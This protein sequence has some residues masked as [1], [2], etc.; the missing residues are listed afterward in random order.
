MTI[1]QRKF[2]R[3]FFREAIAAHD[4]RLCKAGKGP[5]ILTWQEARKLWRIATNDALSHWEK[6]NKMRVGHSSPCLAVHMM[7]GE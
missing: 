4:M 5:M 7:K 6:E 2:R 1:R 3:Y